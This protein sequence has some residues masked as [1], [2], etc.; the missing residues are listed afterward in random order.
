VKY[1]PSPKSKPKSWCSTNRNSSSGTTRWCWVAFTRKPHEWTR[2]ITA[3]CL[4]GTS[5]VRL[6]LWITKH[7]VRF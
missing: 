2:V 4:F 1:R 6:W 5:A 7:P 3:Q